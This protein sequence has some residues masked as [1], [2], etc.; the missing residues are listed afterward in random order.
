[1][2]ENIM[3]IDID[4]CTRCY[5]CEIAC[6][7]ENQIGVGPRWRQIATLGPRRLNG[8]LH[9]DFVP[10]ACIHCDDPLCA[11]L[12]PTDAITKREDGIV[13]IAQ[14]KCTGCQLCLYGCPYGVM[15]YDEEK[16][17]AGKCHFCLDRIDHNLEPS[18]VQHCIG[19]SLQWIREEDLEP[20]TKG[21]HTAR[22]GKVCYRSTK[23]KLS[24]P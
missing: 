6:K 8:D 13:V 23:W 14:D 11:R 18:C 22:L 1:M 12:C 4:Q 24:S 16:A 21:M 2:S 19:G 7:Q 17:V 5:A 9:L 10:T 15:Q 3:L 20:L